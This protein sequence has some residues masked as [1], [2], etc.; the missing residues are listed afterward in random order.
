MGD[1]NQSEKPGWGK[2]IGVFF[3]CG[4]L[5]VGCCIVVSA[6]M[7]SQMGFSG[8]SNGGIMSTV[9]GIGCAAYY[10]STGKMAPAVIVALVLG[11]VIGFLAVYLG[12]RMV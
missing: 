8:Y 9:V 6:T 7:V 11:A 10:R 4:C 2:T 5:A 12:M 1:L 3:L